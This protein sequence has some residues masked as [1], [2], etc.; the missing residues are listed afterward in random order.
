MFNAS[1]SMV[2]AGNHS[3]ISG[4]NHSPTGSSY[5]PVLKGCHSSPRWQPFLFCDLKRS[6][7]TTFAA[8]PFRPSNSRRSTAFVDHVTD[9]VP[10][11]H[12]AEW[13]R[14]RPKALES[15]SQAFEPPLGLPPQ[16]ALALVPYLNCSRP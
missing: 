9:D 16:F 8:G 7:P 2:L 5:M 10:T 3:G 4:L 6:S 14:R 15:I 12:R 11:A 1:R 13:Q